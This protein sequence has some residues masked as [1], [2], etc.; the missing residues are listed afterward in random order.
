MQLFI[1]EFGLYFLQFRLVLR[2]FV[3]VFYCYGIKKVMATLYLTTIQVDIF[4]YTILTKKKKKS[5][6]YF[7]FHPVA[8]TTTK[9]NPIHT[10]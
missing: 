4:Q 8:E 7:F 5:C 3:F 6:Y 2:I 10:V 1:S 9:I